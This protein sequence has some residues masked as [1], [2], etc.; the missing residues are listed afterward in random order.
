MN[1][2]T[3]LWVTRSIDARSCST[4]RTGSHKW[5]DENTECE[6]DEGVPG[7]QWQWHGT[8]ALGNCD[9]VIGNLTSISTAAEDNMFGLAVGGREYKPVIENATIYAITILL[10][11]FCGG[12]GVPQVYLNSGACG[13]D[14]RVVAPHGVHGCLR[15]SLPAIPIFLVQD[16]IS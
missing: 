13:C 14:G 5:V 10:A 3:R 8:S 2:C 9:G 15:D 12:A 7:G 16:S 4:C 1:I 6:R 11:G